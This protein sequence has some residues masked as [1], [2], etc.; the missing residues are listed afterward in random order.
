MDN[1]FA[2]VPADPAVIVRRVRH[3]AAEA[4][5]DGPP[6]ADALDRCVDVTVTEL[7]GSRVKTFVPLLALRRVRCRIRAGSRDR[8]DI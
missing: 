8:E 3:Q 1:V 6:S 2:K 4:Y 7:W 5:L